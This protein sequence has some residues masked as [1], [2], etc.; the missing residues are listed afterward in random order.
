V[1]SLSA[2]LE[3][4]N[5]VCGH[6]WVRRAIGC[7]RIINRKVRKGSASPIRDT[8]A[9]YKTKWDGKGAFMAAELTGLIGFR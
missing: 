6:R 4:G 5:A 2:P 9:K 1:D 8:A 7:G 3:V